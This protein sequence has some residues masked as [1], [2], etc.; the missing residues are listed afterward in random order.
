MNKKGLHTFPAVGLSSLLVIFA[1]LCLAVFALL[2]VSTARADANLSRKNRE[3]ALQ[4]YQAELEADRC[5]ARLRGGEVLPGVNREGDIYTFSCPVSDTKMLEVQVLIQG[6]S[7]RILRWQS[8]STT[9][10]KTDE[11]L[12]VWSGQG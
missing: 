2:T 1:V 6:E 8:V 5:I 4:Y 10:W 7:C 3:A 12:P 11:K 9:H